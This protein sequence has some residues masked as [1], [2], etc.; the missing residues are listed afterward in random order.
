[1]F[2]KCEKCSSED[3]ECLYNI[4]E[5]L[6]GI[7]CAYCGFIHIDYIKNKNTR[8]LFDGQQISKGKRRNIK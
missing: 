2:K 3:I 8:P 5:E 7:I 1:M 4:D 6:K